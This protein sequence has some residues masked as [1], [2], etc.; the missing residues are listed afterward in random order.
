MARIILEVPDELSEQ[1]ARV[2]ERLPELLALSLQQPALSAHIYR[3]ILDFLATGPTREEIL[4]FGPSPDMSDRLKVLLSRN[5]AGE[6]TPSEQQEL[7][8]YERI[9]HL[10]IMLKAGSL[11]YLSRA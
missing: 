2:G 5:K 7:D 8:E 11:P 3:Y 6:L 9:E 4:A 1:L 10:I